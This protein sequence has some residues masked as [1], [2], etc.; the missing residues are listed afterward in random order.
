VSG[1]P[2]SSELLAA[3]VEM[4]VRAEDLERAAAALNA[5]A[6]RVELLRAADEIGA[7][8][9]TDLHRVV[10]TEMLGETD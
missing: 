5:A 6:G 1:D 4:R 9:V 2:R 10:E 8:D 3:I 7:L